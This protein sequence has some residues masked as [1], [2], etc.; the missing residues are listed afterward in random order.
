MDLFPSRS[1]YSHISDVREALDHVT[2]LFASQI[3]RSIDEKAEP[4]TSINGDAAARQAFLI[5][6]DP[7]RQ[8]ELFLRAVRNRHFWPR[9]RSLVGSPPFSFLK[10]EDD[11]VLRAA[12]ITHKRAHMA[13]AQT[14]AT[15]YS[16]F[17]RGH[18]ED[19][20]GR[21]YRI[22]ARRERRE[23]LPYDSLTAGET[24]VFDVRIPKRTNKT[25]ASIIS[26]KQDVAA[27]ISLTFPRA[28]EILNVQRVAILR[29]PLTD[30]GIDTNEVRIRVEGGKQRDSNSP[31]G[32][33]VGKIV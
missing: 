18:Y 10:N 19:G 25:K 24:V 31:I 15:S 1:T 33:F 7:E 21:L 6:L 30:S 17:G 5:L 4:N 3:E 12:G 14:T 9:I 2:D 16:E 23:T 27:M 26:K 11:G 22:V 28:G 32:R 29:L 13:H 20:A 8:R